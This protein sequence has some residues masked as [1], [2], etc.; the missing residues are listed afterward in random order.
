MTTGGATLTTSSSGSCLGKST[1]H[2]DFTSNVYSSWADMGTNFD[3]TARLIVDAIFSYTPING[4][5]PYLR[6]WIAVRSSIVGQSWVVRTCTS[7]VCC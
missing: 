6:D 2:F 7:G 1:I 3:G 4:E 5:E